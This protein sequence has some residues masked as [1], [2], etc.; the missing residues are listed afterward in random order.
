[1]ALITRNTPPRASVMP[2][3][4]TVVLTS[5]LAMAEWAKTTVKLLQI[6]TN[7]L[8]APIHSIK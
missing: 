2:M 6:S 5:P 8:S 1:M 7:V 3:Y 4:F